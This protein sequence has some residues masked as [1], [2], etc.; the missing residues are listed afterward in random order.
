MIKLIV[1]QPGLF[2]TLPGIPAFRTP[3]EV[4]I[5]KSDINLVITELRRYGVED[6]KIIS[7]IEKKPKT[8]VETKKEA[9][10]SS[11]KCGNFNMMDRRLGKIEELLEGFLERNCLV[12]KSNIIDSSPNIV[13]GDI[14]ED[15]FI[16]SIETNH[17][18]IDGEIFMNQN[19]IDDIS[20][21]VELLSKVRK[22]DK[23]YG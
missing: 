15:E 19:E 6:Y 18:K 20:E 7:G 1:K 22:G 4:N 2:L 16:P 12:P 10:S 9:K 11:K 17:L 23:K 5:T 3:V 21:N 13:V 14:V 8:Q